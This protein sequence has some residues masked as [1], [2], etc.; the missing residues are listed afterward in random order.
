LQS[1]GTL[2]KDPTRDWTAKDFFDESERALYAAEFETAIKHLET[3]EA[4]YPFDPYAKQAQLNIAYSYYKFD[5]PDSAIS[6]ADRFLRL[7]PR[8]PLVGSAG[9]GSVRQNG[10]NTWTAA[11]CSAR[12]F[13][14]RRRSWSTPKIEGTTTRPG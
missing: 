12:T 14:C 1:C 10:S 11:P 8:S 2:D 4:R 3:L 6:A 9:P 5:E 13:A 7:H